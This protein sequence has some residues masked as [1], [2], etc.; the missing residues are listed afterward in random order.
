MRVRAS[1]F[2]ALLVAGTLSAQESTPSAPP[3]PAKPDYSRQ[4]IM[5]LLM[6]DDDDED[7]DRQRRPSN[8][9]HFG[10]VEFHAL[11]TDWRFNYLPLMVPLSGTAFG[12]NATTQTW[13]DPFA[14]T[15]TQIATS[16]RAWRTRRNIKAELRRIDKS[17]RAKL[18]I[19]A[20]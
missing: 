2:A 3:P 7:T 10:A 12:M 20:N 9:D 16:Q 4:S 5:R 17:E 14:L 8:F 6:N 13:P 11:G 18:K 19:R 15:H 1:I